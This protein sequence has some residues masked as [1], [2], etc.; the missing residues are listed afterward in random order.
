MLD[1]V[2]GSNVGVWL[3]LEVFSGV[4]RGVTRGGGVGVAWRGGVM[5]L[6]AIPP[7]VSPSSALPS[8]AS[9]I[10][11]DQPKLLA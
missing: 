7:R 6:H 2:L 1:G 3:C 5:W 11:V 9:H 4:L 8:P 10:R